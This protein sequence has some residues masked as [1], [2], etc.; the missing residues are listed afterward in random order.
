MT[1]LCECTD[2]IATCKC[3]ETS[4]SNPSKVFIRSNISSLSIL[5]CSGLEVK[6]G[7][8]NGASGLKQI[9]FE[10]IK[11][12]V[13]RDKGLATRLATQV[14]CTSIN[15]STVA[16][17]SNAFMGPCHKTI[18]FE[19]C[20]FKEILASR[21]FSKLT[22]LESL[23]IIGSQIGG[24]QR[25]AI[26][27]NVEM[28]TFHFVGNN[29]THKMSK[30]A[31]HFG[32]RQ[33]VDVRQNYFGH[34]ETEAF[35][36]ILPL[37]LKA[38]LKLFNNTVLA[39]DKGALTFNAKLFMDANLSFMRQVA[40]RDW[41]IDK[42]CNCHRFGQ[43][44]N[45][46]IGFTD[47][48]LEANDHIYQN[49]K[50]KV[51]NAVLCTRTSEDHAIMVVGIVEYREES[52]SP[53]IDISNENQPAV[54]QLSLCSRDNACQ[55]TGIS[56]KCNCSVEK[57]IYIGVNDQNGRVYHV[58]PQFKSLEIQ[59]CSLVSINQPKLKH[60]DQLVFKNISDLQLY[61]AAALQSD[62]PVNNASVKFTIESSVMDTIRENTFAND[63]FYSEISLKNVTVNVI[64]RKSFNKCKAGTISFDAV[65][66]KNELSILAMHDVTVDKFQMVNSDIGRLG[67]EAFG[68][69][70]ESSLTLTGNHFEHINK[71]A[72]SN[73]LS[74][75][76]IVITITDNF[77]NTF[78]DGA[79]AFQSWFPTRDSETNLV[80]N[81]LNI[82]CGCDLHMIASSNGHSKHSLH[83]ESSF[84][85][86]LCHQLVC[87]DK[88]E[89]V[90]WKE[91]D[92]YE[93]DDDP[94]HN[95]QQSRHMEDDHGVGFL[96]RDNIVI[97][98]GVGVALLICLLVVV[99]GV[100]TC[101]RPNILPVMPT[102]DD[103]VHDE[104]WHFRRQSLL[105]NPQSETNKLFGRGQSVKEPHSKDYIGFSSASPPSY[106]THPPQHFPLRELSSSP[107]ARSRHLGHQLTANGIN[108][109]QSTALASEDGLVSAESRDVF[110]DDR[111]DRTL[112]VIQDTRLARQSLQAF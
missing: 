31:F 90:R 82:P 55:C 80:N 1:S 109:C 23:S 94:E 53:N 49:V 63:L 33:T 28:Q 46:L 83:D 103:S 86:D 9:H 41:A 12:L 77:I 35:S 54:R 76:D 42:A 66:I 111:F 88:N 72:F 44:I 30:H 106:K 100:L 57:D 60:L 10:H 3:V 50:S 59:G 20:K 101:R 16:L 27:P 91:Y 85:N 22:Q 74:K 18:H 40:L 105:S 95:H 61:T 2:T 11:D 4:W 79:L 102:G 29:V 34:I 24:I 99:I 8:L 25:G 108:L 65:K 47:G 98:V 45:D 84:V 89:Y 36:Q 51:E 78:E 15:S 13:V 107:R 93:C 19:D 92:L 37:S 14:I 43:V 81:K 87:L 70:L 75:Q 67:T 17:S 39:F 62:I 21:T 71:E 56:I 5:H 48:D 58:P 26:G 32:F 69:N 97:L 52:C 7:S 104:N 68:L 64:G 110:V 112:D 6:T 96:S 73:V 38:E